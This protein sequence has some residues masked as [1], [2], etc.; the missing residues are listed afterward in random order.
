MTSV[1]LWPFAL[2]SNYI[3]PICGWQDIL[4]DVYSHS[5]SF[6]NPH[7]SLGFSNK[8]EWMSQWRTCCGRRRKHWIETPIFKLFSIHLLLHRLYR[9][10]YQINSMC[11]C[12]II[13][14]YVLHRSVSYWESLSSEI[15]LYS[16]RKQKWIE[17]Q[18]W[19][20]NF[21]PMFSTTS[22]TS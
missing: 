6:L 15:F 20:V 8:K 4:S 14:S 13:E 16:L 12:V 3:S 22:A 2:I 18:L 17:T 19:K 11:N 9:F 7:V 5:W 21:N 1:W 10:Y